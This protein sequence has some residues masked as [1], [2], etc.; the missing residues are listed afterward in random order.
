MKCNPKVSIIIPVY[1]AEKWLEKCI[2]SCIQQTYKNIEIILIDDGSPDSSG[3]ICDS[4]SRADERVIVI[5][6]ENQGVSSARNKGISVSKGEYIIFVDSDDWIKSNMIEELLRVSNCDNGYE[7]VICGYDVINNVH[8]IS[9]CSFFEK[10]ECINEILTELSTRKKL[11]MFQTPWNK[12][13]IS[14]VIKD[15]NIRFDESLKYGEDFSFV[16][17]YIENIHSCTIT[18]NCLYSFRVIKKLN[19]PHYQLNDINYHWR[20]NIVL[21]NNY[22]SLFKHTGTYDQYKERLY[23]FLVYRIKVSLND[24]IANG[25]SNKDVIGFLSKV[26][27]SRYYYAICKADKNCLND[28]LEWAVYFCVKNKLLNTLYY[29]FRIKAIIKAVKTRQ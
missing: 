26:C 14:R 5:H 24:F 4:Y 3:E 25:V 22:S 7:L 28:I 27:K 11:S 18:D 23:C 16:L 20:N 13:Y 2:D 1:K 6:Q 10:Y 17:K 19:K 15:N 21:W 29:C 8:K 12:L 9:S